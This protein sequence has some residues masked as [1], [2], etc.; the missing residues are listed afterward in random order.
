MSIE[1]LLKPRYKVQAN[2]PYSPFKKG[3]IITFNGLS[4]GKYFHEYTK[5]APVHLEADEDGETEYP[6]I[7]M[8]VAWHYERAIED[9]PSYLSYTND[10]GIIDF[11]LKVEK[12]IFHNGSTILWAF[13]YL[14]KQEP[15]IKRMSLDGWLP[16]SETEYLAHQSNS[17]TPHQ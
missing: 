9:M 12:Y 14:W 1:D 8:E 10:S 17:E 7:F 16:S 2:Y 3:Q 11:V 15:D 5:E 6:A 4:Q 13:E